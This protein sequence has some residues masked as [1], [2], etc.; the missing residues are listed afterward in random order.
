MHVSNLLFKANL[1]E[2][3]GESGGLPLVGFPLTTQKRQKFLPLL[4]K[5]VPRFIVYL[6]WSSLQ[7]LG[8]TA[9]S[10][11]LVNPLKNI[12]VIIP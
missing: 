4:E 1:G 11:F 9:N 3:G 10:R 2:N 8:K 6:A 7:M 12:T 5:F